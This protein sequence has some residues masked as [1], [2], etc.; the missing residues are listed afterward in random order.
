MHEVDTCHNL[1]GVLWSWVRV[2]LQ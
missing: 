2:Q 1:Y